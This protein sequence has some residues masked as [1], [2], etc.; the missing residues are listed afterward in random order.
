MLFTA[1]VDLFVCSN[2]CAPARCANVWYFTS[3]LPAQYLNSQQLCGWWQALWQSFDL[4]RRVSSCSDSC[5]VQIVVEAS[6]PN[7]FCPACYVIWLTLSSTF[8][9]HLF[10][11]YACVRLLCISILT[12]FMCLSQSHTRPEACSDSFPI[13]FWNLSENRLGLPRSQMGE[14]RTQR[15]QIHNLQNRLSYCLSCFMLLKYSIISASLPW[16]ANVAIVAQICQSA[17]TMFLACLLAILT[18]VWYLAGM[19]LLFAWSWLDLMLIQVLEPP[20]PAQPRQQAKCKLSMQLAVCN[21]VLTCVH[22]M[23]QIVPV[24][25]WCLLVCCIFFKP[26]GFAAGSARRSEGWGILCNPL[27]QTSIFDLQDCGQGAWCSGCAEPGPHLR[28]AGTC[29]GK[30]CEVYRLGLGFEV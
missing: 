1:G 9:Q 16:K 15:V 7:C 18:D 3:W 10:E 12:H 17:L 19:F 6:M 14:I 22:S 26:E 13:C 4:T 25:C 28:W 8:L 21:V 5:I 30:G 27:A 24:R 20:E 29:R 11:I 23:F 2:A